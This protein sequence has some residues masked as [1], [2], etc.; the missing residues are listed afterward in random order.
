M[1]TIDY[2][3]WIPQGQFPADVP[4][5]WTPASTIG[6]LVLYVVHLSQFGAR[7]A[8]PRLLYS[9]RMPV[10]PEIDTLVAYEPMLR[11]EGVQVTVDSPAET[12]S[13][14]LVS[15][16]QYKP[17]EVAMLLVEDHW[18]RHSMRTSSI[19]LKRIYD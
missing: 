6:L 11:P 17:E 15:E 13:T 2:C 12:L 4:V 8:G 16:K 5:E 19:G 7:F 3:E 10:R 9:V 1:R 18:G 14:I